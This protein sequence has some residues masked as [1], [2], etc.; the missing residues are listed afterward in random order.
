MFIY[1]LTSFLKSAITFTFVLRYNMGTTTMNDMGT[2]HSLVQSSSKLDTSS[3]IIVY[4]E[5]E[6]N[7]DPA[8]LVGT[9]PRTE[10]N[11]S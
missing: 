5:Q 6:T 9:S 2:G 11:W 4:V 1:A 7:Q 3:V 8:G 10:P